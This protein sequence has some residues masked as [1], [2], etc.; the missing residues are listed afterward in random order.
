MGLYRANPSVVMNTERSFSKSREYTSLFSQAVYLVS[1]LLEIYRL[2]EREVLFFFFSLKS[3]DEKECERIKV[4][5]TPPI[6]LR[7]R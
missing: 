3:G 1:A 5:L 4:S 7:S 2:F 6:I